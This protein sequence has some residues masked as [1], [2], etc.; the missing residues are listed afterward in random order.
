LAGLEFKPL[1]FHLP[2]K[3]Y[4]IR[5]YKLGRGKKHK[6]ILKTVSQTFISK[7]GVVYIPD[8]YTFKLIT[9]Y[10]SSN[11]PVY[12]YPISFSSQYFFA[13]EPLNTDYIIKKSLQINNNPDKSIKLY[14]I[15]LL[16]Q[17]ESKFY[18]VFTLRRFEEEINKLIS[19]KDYYQ[20]VLE[21]YKI[22]TLNKGGML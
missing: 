4:H 6:R 22:K 20:S 13:R 2:F 7:V 10:F 21:N 8:E 5:V 14:L 18:Q 11:R 15:G 9:L 19:N 3:I 17:F 16:H 1:L 12:V